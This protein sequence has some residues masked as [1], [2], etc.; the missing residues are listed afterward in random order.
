MSLIY[1]RKRIIIEIKAK[2]MGTPVTLVLE[3]GA[4]L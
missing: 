2:T 4:Q 3:L 1:G